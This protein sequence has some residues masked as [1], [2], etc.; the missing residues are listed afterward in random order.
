MMKI[1][2]AGCCA[3]MIATPALACRG[4]AEFPQA[5][6]KLAEANL[7]QTEKDA[8]A[9]RLVEGEA[10]HKRGHDLD[11]KQIRLESLQIL[12]EIRAKID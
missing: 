12:D 5:K 10:L 3:V 7:P 8:Y 9:V 6:V 4:T 1:V 11:T 2:L